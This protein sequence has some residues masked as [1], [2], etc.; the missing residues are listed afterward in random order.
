MNVSISSNTKSLNSKFN[1]YFTDKE[2]A[3]AEKVKNIQIVINKLNSIWEG[4]KKGKGDVNVMKLP[5][6]LWAEELSI[7]GASKYLFNEEFKKALY[8]FGEKYPEY[9]FKFYPINNWINW[10]F[11]GVSLGMEYEKKKSL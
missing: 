10:F 7:M 5:N 6:N 1:K 9:T 4:E 11:G 3:A 2:K 8:E